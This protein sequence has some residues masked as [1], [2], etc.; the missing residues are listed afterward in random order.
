MLTEQR[1][2]RSTH[3]DTLSTLQIL[4]IINDEDAIITRVVRDALPSIAQAVDTITERLQRGGRLI[5]VGAGTSGRLGV[6]DAVECVPTYSTPPEL[7][8]A[9]IAG[10][11]EAITNSIEGAEDNAEAGRDDL[12]ALDI[13]PVDAV[14][15]IAAS[16]RTP[17]VLGAL[18]TANKIGALTVGISCNTPAPLLNI[19]QIDIALLVGPEI[20]TGSTRMKAGTAQKLVLNM[21]STTTMIKLGKVYGNLMV[22]VRPSNEKL[23]DRARRII[24]DV[25]GVSYEQASDLLTQS[26]QEVKTAI[27]MSILEVTAEQARALLHQKKGLLHQVIGK[28]ES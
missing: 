25:T 6:L 2:P 15:G 11:Y 27:I 4:Q 10:G 28:K 16:G 3:I 26:G 20:I 23:V 18:D 12:L 17:Y 19:S 21:I 13:A 1:N 9:I 22:D 24:C 8:Q 5:Y 14:V 7:V